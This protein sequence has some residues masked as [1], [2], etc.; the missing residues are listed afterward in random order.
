MPSSVQKEM[1]NFALICIFSEDPRERGGA[2]GLTN[3]KSEL[4]DTVR[5]RLTRGIRSIKIKRN[6]KQR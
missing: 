3:K 6:A 1:A 4:R 2:K 5:L